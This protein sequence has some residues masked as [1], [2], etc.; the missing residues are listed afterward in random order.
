MT[1]HNPLVSVVMSVRDGERTIAQ[2]VRSVLS[3]TLAELEL[4]VIDDGSDDGT[5]K[6]V[7]D[8]ARRDPRLRLLSHG[9]RG[10]AESLNRGIAAARGDFIARLD[11]DDLSLPDRLA[12]QVECMDSLPELA[13]L[14]SAAYLVSP[15]G[16]ALRIVEPPLTDSAIRG[17]LLFDNPFIHSAVML[18]R[19]TL[20]RGGL[21]YNPAY[22]HCEDYELWSRLLERGQGMNLPEPLVARREHPAQTSRVAQEACLTWAERIA[23]ANLRRL[24]LDLPIETVRRL[25]GWLQ[26]RPQAGASLDEGAIEGLLAVLARLERDP[27]LDP[28]EVRLLRGRFMLRL[29]GSSGLRC[30]NRFKPGDIGA[31]A[32][33]LRQRS[34]RARAQRRRIQQAAVWLPDW[35]I[36]ASA[37]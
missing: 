4:I 28:R 5:A 36:E 12:R 27:R 26:I 1:A 10:L 13:I 16:G 33:Y 32:V 30:L 6:I 9:K 37:R 23:Q 14:G 18:R 2:A 20:R 24:G 7:A 15:T 22:A 34:R 29:A 8:D 31:L 25:R 19:E 3:Q 11:A 35:Q 21:D 17:A